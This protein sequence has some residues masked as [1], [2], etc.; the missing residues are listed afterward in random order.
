MKPTR[1]PDS[2]PGDWFID[3]ACIDC[4]AS[5]HVA[6]D[7]IVDRNGKSVSVRQPTTPAE[8]L[9]AWRAAS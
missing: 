1:N 8:E 4:G 5:R 3:T 7:L 2:A 6:S 9:A